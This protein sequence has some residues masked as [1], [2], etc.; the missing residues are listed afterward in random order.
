MLHPSTIQ[1]LRLHFSFFLLPVYLF[2][3][4]QVPNIS[5][6]R[7]VVIFVILHVLVYPSSNAYNSWMD[8]DTS[9]IGGLAAPLQPT[10]Q[11]FYTSVIMDIMALV[12]SAFV[13][14]SFL[15]GILLYILASRAYS[16]RG[17]RLKRFPVIGFLTVFVCQGFL[18]FFI[19]YQGVSDLPL[20]DIPLLPC[21][22]SSLLIGALYPLTQIYQHDA[23]V[24]DGVYTI[25]YVLGKTGTFLF[26]MFLFLL[27]TAML[28]L[29]FRRQQLMSQ[30]YLFL[31]IMLPVVLYFLYWMILVWKREQQ[32]NFS[33]SLRMIIVATFCTTT[34]FFIQIITHH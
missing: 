22:I 32:A 12:L 25:S 21:F 3:L 29:L 27:S 7:A 13:S 1:L 15:L 19:T 30:W 23:D 17:I 11:L 14:V 31:L 28:L 8:K 26:S 6:S 20:S 34:F 4:S 2:A 33:N 16:Y 18:I 24:A 10:R 5:W 9:A